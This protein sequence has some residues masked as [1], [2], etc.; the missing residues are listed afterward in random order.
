MEKDLTNEK[1]PFILQN[2][3][4]FKKFKP[5]KLIGKGTFSNVYVSQ[6]IEKNTYVALKVEQRKTEGVQLLE[7]EAFFLYSLKGVGIPEVISYGRTKSYN[8]L[9]LP[10]LDISLLDLFILKN[11]EI[12]LNDICLIAKQILDRIEW[13]HS[14]N[15]IYRDIKPENFLFGKKDPEILY[16]IDFGLCRK[17]KSSK[18]GKHIL[19]RNLGKFTGTS[20]YASVYA[21]G[22]NE[23][24]R[25][26]DIESIGYMIIFLMKK[27]LPWQ[28]IKGS[29]YKEC[30]T[31]LYLM[32]KNIKP[33]ELCEGIPKEMIDYIKNVKSLKFEEEP[34]YQ[35]FKNL[36]DI[37][38][39]KNDFN[40]EK[41]IFS[42]VKNSN[43]NTSNKLNSFS[44]KE[45]KSSPYKRLYGKIKD[46]IEKQKTEHKLKQ[47]EKVDTDYSS[48]NTNQKK[49]LHSNNENSNASINNI[50]N[51]NII[52]DINQGNSEQSNTMKVMYNKNIN[53][54]LKGNNKKMLKMNY[55]NSGMNE[56]RKNQLKKK[57]CPPQNKI[58]KDCYINNQLPKRSDTN[59][60]SLKKKLPNKNI[61]NKKNEIKKSLKQIDDK[62]NDYNKYKKNN[63]KKM[64]TLKDFSYINKNDNTFYKNNKINQ[65]EINKKDNN[66]ENIINDSLL[67]KINI[68]D[69]MTYNSLKTFNTFKSK[70]ETLEN[71]SKK[72]ILS[73]NIEPNII[74]NNKRIKHI[75]FKKNN[76]KMESNN[77]ERIYKTL[78]N[79]SNIKNND[80]FINMYKRDLNINKNNLYED[81]IFYNKNKIMKLNNRNRRNN[82]EGI[83][84]KNFSKYMLDLLESKQINYNNDYLRNIEHNNTYNIYNINNNSIDFSS[85]KK[86][87]SYN[88]RILY[89]SYKGNNIYNL[90]G[91]KKINN[92]YEIK[93]NNNLREI[94]N[95][96]NLSGIN[97][98][99]N[100]IDRKNI[101]NLNGINSIKNLSGINNNLKIK[102]INFINNYKINNINN[103][104]N[105]KLNE[106]NY[107]LK[108]KY[109]N[110][111]RTNSINIFDLKNNNRLIKNRCN[112]FIGIDRMDNIN[113]R[114]NSISYKN[115]L[116]KD[117]NNKSEL[118]PN[119]N[120]YR[121]YS[122]N[123]E[124]KNKNLIIK[125]GIIPKQRYNSENKSNSFL[126]RKYNINNINKSK[127]FS[128]LFN[129][130]NSVNLY[131]NYN[132]ITK[133]QN[134]NYKSI[135][136]QT[137]PSR[138]SNSN[139][140]TLENS[141]SKNNNFI[142]NINIKYGNIVDINNNSNRINKYKM[143]RY[144]GNLN[145]L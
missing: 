132:N 122:L 141:F 85:I 66:I 67:D 81:K 24:S 63:I 18:T 129:S 95:Y 69:L 90:S 38:L 84:G 86:N 75:T 55:E 57:N 1:D 138:K 124:M 37:I 96:N 76:N 20:R 136:A 100:Y 48:S 112:N 82:S 28:G 36:F 19:P 89:N 5:I 71:L 139:N 102:N 58:S 73:Y 40:L 46:N 68:N 4:F 109:L 54:N 137:V 79:N 11:K 12:N 41:N 32:K 143:S 125:N 97:S 16:L 72:N 142:N 98:I 135:F 30:Y 103:I 43:S 22:G 70:N 133:N 33:E 144:K 130:N 134:K 23:Q 34:N 110:I 27:K 115:S 91:L 14:K 77:R 65:I 107:K 87:K 127:I 31:K 45:R 83:D 51:T 60:D 104:N 101:N 2:K 8:I 106:Y 59:I 80:S 17:Y 145:F 74:E 128:N 62:D 113:K 49:N 123:K 94:K 6:N 21:L 52:K 131:S 105:I 140:F 53:I 119:Y 120:N 114:F 26:D 42:W 39:K 126:T 88:N 108:N 9:V 35:Y 111:N 56:D 99:H 50:T 29:S 61:I 118:I 92:L 15:I 25:R 10:L 47:S 13:V 121:N 44:I 3:L 93:N 7:S 116:S 64:N 117:R 78:N